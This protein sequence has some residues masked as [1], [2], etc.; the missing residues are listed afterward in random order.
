MKI[1]LTLWTWCSGLLQDKES[2]VPENCHK[3]TV[4]P[5]ASA[6]WEVQT[7]S[8]MQCYMWLCGQHYIMAGWYQCMPSHLQ[9]CDV[10]LCNCG[11][12]YIMA[13]WLQ[14]IITH[15]TTVRWR[16][17][18]GIV[19]STTKRVTMLVQ[20]SWQFLE[21]CYCE[22]CLFQ[23]LSPTHCTPTADMHAWACNVTLL[24]IRVNYDAVP[25]QHIHRRGN[26]RR[27]GY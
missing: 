7:T 8:V 12:R 9:L 19:L 11:Q 2:K 18:L 20:H 14:C 23:R 1:L 6:S 4:Y 22:R 13:G 16:V 27:I 3:R 21:Y 5:H 10:V 25:T 15:N 24:V 26:S 17:S